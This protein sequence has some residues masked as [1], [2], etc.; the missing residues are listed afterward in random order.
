MDSHP[1][2][3]VGGNS[4]LPP[5]SCS[6]SLEEEFKEGLVTSEGCCGQ[7]EMEMPIVERL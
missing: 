6:Q 7:E 4:S 2:N 1:L 3:H 5:S